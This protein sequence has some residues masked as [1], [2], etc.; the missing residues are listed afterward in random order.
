MNVKALY[1]VSYGL[2]VVGS[3]KGDKLN[4]QIA[5]TVIQVMFRAGKDW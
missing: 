5:N 4:A 2:Y 3:N 1:L